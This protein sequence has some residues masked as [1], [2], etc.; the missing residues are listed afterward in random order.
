MKIRQSTGEAV[1][2]ALAEMLFEA[3]CIETNGAFD[4][5]GKKDNIEKE[6]REAF[7]KVCEQFEIDTVISDI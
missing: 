6:V 2:D 1:M 7:M 4:F 5:E 3:V